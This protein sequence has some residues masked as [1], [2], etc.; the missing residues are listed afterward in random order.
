MFYIVD[1]GLDYEDHATWHVRMPEEATWAELEA[2]LRVFRSNC[3]VYTQIREDGV[4]RGAE[5]FQDL[6]WFLDP[7]DLLDLGPS[8]SVGDVV[9]YRLGGPEFGTFYFR[10]ARVGA[11][12]EGALVLHSGSFRAD[13]FDAMTPALASSIFG[14]W[15]AFPDAN[16][17]HRDLVAILREEWTRR[18]SA[19]ARDLEV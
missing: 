19:A 10:Y 4:V 14:G 2:F 18:Q 16:E 13:L 11:C 1:N 8:S 5:G 12:P 7:S 9:S 17:G 3:A 15:D 6:G